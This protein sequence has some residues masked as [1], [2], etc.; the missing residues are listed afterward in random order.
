[1]QRMTL[2][3]I[4]AG[5]GHIWGIIFFHLSTLM[6]YN[7]RIL[8]KVMQHLFVIAYRYSF[9]KLKA[10]KNKTCS[11]WSLARFII[12]K[13]VYVI[14]HFSIFIFGY[15]ALIRLQLVELGFRQIKRKYDTIRYNTIHTIQ[16]NTIQH[17]TI[18]Y[19]TIQYT[20]IQY[21]TIQYNTYNTI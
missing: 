2:N 14:I 5:Y 10:F 20:T 11:V 12:Y 18:Q 21:N 1:M 9:V 4:S 6:W 17:N 8:W 13:I 7:F 16:Y 3:E 19:S 15:L